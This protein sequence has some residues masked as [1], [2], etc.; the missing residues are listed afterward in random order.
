MLEAGSGVWA[1]SDETWIVSRST[2]KYSSKAAN[3]LIYIFSLG[4]ID[5][6]FL[7]RSFA[8]NIFWRNFIVRLIYFQ[9]LSLTFARAISFHVA[10]AA[11]WIWTPKSGC[12]FALYAY[13]CAADGAHCWARDNGAAPGLPPH[14]LPNEA[15]APPGWSQKW[16]AKAHTHLRDI[17]GF[18]LNASLYQPASLAPLSRITSFPV[19][20]FFNSQFEKKH[21]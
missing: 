16:N 6:G 20:C 5:E 19:C 9:Q 3:K 17:Y 15:C 1:E 11:D 7:L 12:S 13:V 4:T 18:Y 10:S 14:E 2:N 8:S 21:V